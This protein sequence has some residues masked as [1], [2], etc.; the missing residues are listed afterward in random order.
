MD[1]GKYVS[2][3]DLDS[4]GEAMKVKV[5]FAL[6]EEPPTE[7]IVVKDAANAGEYVSVEELKPAGEGEFRTQKD[8]MLVLDTPVNAEK[9][10]SVE[11]LELAAEAI[12]EEVGAS[13][14]TQRSRKADR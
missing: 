1:T 9:Y 13:A 10:V 2:V 3:E 5:I 8:P 11:E 6:D 14:L 7:A 4:G 12:V